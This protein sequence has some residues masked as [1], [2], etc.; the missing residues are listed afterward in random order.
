MQGPAAGRIMFGSDHPVFADL[1]DHAGWIDLLF[2]EAEAEGGLEDA[3][4]ERLFSSN[5]A[6]FL[7]R[8][9]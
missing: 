4:W 5:P 9:A 1:I 7:R 6:A 2:D 8:P 3:H